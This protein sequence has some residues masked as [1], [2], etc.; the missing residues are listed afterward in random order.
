M[1]ENT[2]N[3][4]LNATTTNGTNA[5]NG[6]TNSNFDFAEGIKVIQKMNYKGNLLL[7]ED[8]AEFHSKFSTSSTT[9]VK[10]DEAS[11]DETIRAEKKFKKR[12]VILP[13]LILF[14]GFF[15][16]LARNY[17]NARYVGVDY[18]GQVSASQS[19]DSREM[20][21]MDGG[22]TG[23]FVVDYVVQVFDI[24]GNSRNISF[25]RR[26]GSEF[27]PGDFVKIYASRSL[28]LSEQ[29]INVSDVPENVLALITAE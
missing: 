6:Q 19:M 7:P 11:A 21:T 4:T 22:G 14:L 27:Q 25:T 15:G 20:L 12:F 18:W 5:N 26:V 23:E 3:N 1:S 17:Y 13:L 16:L 10:S 9:G 29:R 2:T 8:N 28:S 24:D